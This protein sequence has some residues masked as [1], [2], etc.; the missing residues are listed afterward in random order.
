[1]EEDLK[2]VPYQELEKRLDYYMDKLS[3]A[4]AWGKPAGPIH[5]RREAIV[6]E[7]IRR[8]PPKHGFGFTGRTR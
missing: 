3:D 5:A 4:K 2:T 8:A 7:M 6:R 1:M